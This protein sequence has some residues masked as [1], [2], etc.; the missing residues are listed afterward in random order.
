MA[1]KIRIDVGGQPY[2]VLNRANARLPI[3][4]KEED[5]QLFE[6]ILADACEKFHMRL[7]AYC[8]MSNH[9]HL[10]IYPK[11]DGDMQ[12]FMQWLTLTHTQR[13]HIQNKT[14]GSGHLYQGRYKSIM[15]E[16]SDT[17]L[18]ALIRYVER[19]PLRANLV[20]NLSNWRFSSYWRRAHGTSEQQR[21]LSPWP[22]EM[23][24]DYRSF[25]HAKVTAEELDRIRSTVR[26]GLLYGSDKWTLKMQEK[27]KVPEMRRVGRPKNGT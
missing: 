20:R 25:L 22:I 1:R 12:S 2:H 7:L 3:F 23:P 8:L 26:K 13:W 18:L 24:T 19:N 11:E 27:Y 15:I 6:A 4:F 5:F 16:K 14:I 17:H 9:F 21:L 10:V